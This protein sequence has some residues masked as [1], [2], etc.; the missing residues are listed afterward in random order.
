[1]NAAGSASKAA[2]VSVE[3]RGSAVSGGICLSGGVW[4]LFYVRFLDLASRRMQVTGG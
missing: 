3:Y 2:G 4:R 1:M